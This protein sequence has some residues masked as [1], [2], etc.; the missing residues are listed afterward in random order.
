MKETDVYHSV[1]CIL[2][3][4]HR[5]EPLA[6]LVPHLKEPD[7]VAFW[8]WYVTG[9]LVV[10]RDLVMTTKRCP[11]GQNTPQTTRAHGITGTPTL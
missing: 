6:N 5:T 1:A 2:T 7:I 9:N 11:T 10:K 3:D 8:G 4:R